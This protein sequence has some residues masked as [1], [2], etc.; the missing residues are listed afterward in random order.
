[1]AR[2]AVR[3]RAAHATVRSMRRAVQLMWQAMWRA[4]IQPEVQLQG[5]ARLHDLVSPSKSCPRTRGRAGT[6][7]V[8]PACPLTCSSQ[9]CESAR[10][11][12][13]TSGIDGDGQ[14][15]GA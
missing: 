13:S 14:A 11:R 5:A 10:R 3:P 4:A 6:S 1:M 8:F 7:S 2:Q 15:Q 12:V 9:T